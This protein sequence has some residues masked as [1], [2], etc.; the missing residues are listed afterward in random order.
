MTTSTSREVGWVVMIGSG[1]PA[2][3]SPLAVLV[4]RRPPHLD[5]IYPVRTMPSAGTLQ[6]E[7]GRGGEKAWKFLFHRTM[8]KVAGLKAT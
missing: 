3:S 8:G 4:S 5:L 1:G 6:A 7:Q 2:R